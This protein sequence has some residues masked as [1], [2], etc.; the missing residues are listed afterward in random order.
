MTTRGRPPPTAG[1]RHLALFARNF[2]A[3]VRFYTDV[4]GMRI[5]WRPD[6]DN[7][8]LT[9][10][11]DNLALH[12]STRESDGDQRLDHIG[13]IIDR[14]ED[15]DAWH[16][17]LIAEGVEIVHPPKTH[18]DGARSLYCRDPDGTSVQLIYHPP[19]SAGKRNAKLKP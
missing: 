10:G 11:N 3:T 16:T 9:N 13:F 8:Y 15:V 1:L 4:M 17:F 19:L 6:A 2:E 7:C 12:R 14:I 18:R 5:E